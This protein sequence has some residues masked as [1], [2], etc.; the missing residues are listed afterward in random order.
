MTKVSIII[1]CYNHG[2]Y[3][4]EAVAS[5]LNQT[6]QDIEIII[7]NDGSIDAMTNELLSHYQ[8]PKTRVITTQNQGLAMARNTGIQAAKGVYIL[9]LDAD[10]RIAPT[11]IEKA[12][13]ILDTNPKIGIVYCNAEFFGAQQGIWSLP[14]YSLATELNGNCLFCTSLFRKEAWEQVG[15]YKKEMKYGWEDYE[16]WLSLLEKGCEVYKIPEVL[17][18]YRQHVTAS[19]LKSIDEEKRNYLYN[20][21][22][23]FHQDLYKTHKKFLKA[24]IKQ[25]FKAYNHAFFYKSKTATHRIYHIGKFTLKFKRK[26]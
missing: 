14:E 22:F 18:Y 6:Y 15:G 3:V 23:S 7:V 4:D 10:D 25:L 21:I 8:K 5:C 1:P 16:F 20:V 19:M 17:F 26:K 12:V 11:Y 24:D 9:P 2:K 13:K